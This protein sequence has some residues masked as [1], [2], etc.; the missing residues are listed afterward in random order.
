MVDS[1]ASLGHDLFQIPKADTVTQI[2]AHAQQDDLA[3]EMAP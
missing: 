2:P 3:F 1:E